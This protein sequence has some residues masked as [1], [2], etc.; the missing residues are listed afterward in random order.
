MAPHLWNGLSDAARTKRI[1]ETA[2]LALVAL[3][4]DGPGKTAIPSL[5]HVIESLRAT[6]READAR[7]LAI[8]AALVLGL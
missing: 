6:G 4:E 7:A 1:G 8:E 2:A 3:G 5:Q